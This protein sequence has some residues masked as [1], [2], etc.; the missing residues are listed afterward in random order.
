MTTCFLAPDPIQSTQFIP[1][2]NTPANGGQLFFYLAGT[3]TKTTV[4]KDNAAATPWTNP[5]VL[6]SGGNLPSGGEVWIP[7]GITIKVVF[8][9][10]NDTDPPTSPYWTKD[11]LSGVNDVS[12]ISGVEW[13]AGP[14]P[15]FVAATRFR[16]SGDQRTTFD[17]GRRVQATV[18]AGTAYATITSTVFATGSTTVGVSTSNSNPLDSGLSAVNYSILNG[19]N[20]SVPM[21]LGGQ[22]VL[23]DPSDRTK[24]GAFNL[25]NV[26]SGAIRQYSLQDSDGTLAYVQEF[27]YSTVAGP[28]GRLKLPNFALNGFKITNSGSSDAMDIG[29]GQSADSANVSTIISSGLTRKTNAAFAAGASSGAKMGAAAM[30][31]NTWYAWYALLGTSGAV[32]FGFDTIFPPSVP[33]T[34]AAFPNYRYIGSRRTTAS[35]TLW[36]QVTVKTTGEGEYVWWNQPGSGALDLNGSVSTASRGLY[37][38]TNLPPVTCVWYGRCWTNPGTG[39]TQTFAFTDPAIP[40]TAPTS[41]NYPLSDAGNA[42]A[43]TNIV[44]DNQVTAWTST[45]VLGIQQG[46]NSAQGLQMITLGWLDPRSSTGAP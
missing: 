7:Q 32:D 5:I 39:S 44:T 30:S 17:V 22:P 37:R 26:S 29:S 42:T 46:G 27:N 14:T 4:Y 28:S 9:P 1:G 35:T 18:T 10:S 25:A 31:S 24:Q 19:T 45:G 40:T 20:P 12:G 43:G 36:D 34:T 2:G 41:Q 33:T 21:L 8:A 11:N 15:T 38:L 3:S 16:V 23:H 6:D 13:I